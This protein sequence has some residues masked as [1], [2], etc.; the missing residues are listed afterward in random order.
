VLTSNQ[1]S[2]LHGSFPLFDA[3]KYKLLDE[4]IFTKEELA[5]I[6]EHGMRNARLLTIAPTG[7]TSL[8]ADNVSSG[9]EPIFGFTVDRNIK[10]EDGS[11]TLHENIP[12]YF[13]KRITELG[14]KLESFPNAITS[15][16]VSPEAQIEMMA[17]F[18]R[19]I[20]GAISKTINLPAD[21]KFE[22]EKFQNI[23][24]DAWKKGLKGTTIYRPNENL[25]VVI[26]KAT[27]KKLPVKEIESKGQLEIFE[28]EPSERHIV[29]GD[30][31]E[32]I[33]LNF[34]Y[35]AKTKRLKEV[36]VSIPKNAGYVDGKFKNKVFMEKKSTWTTIC[37]LISLG[38]RQG[39][40]AEKIIHQLESSSY[41]TRDLSS[42]IK[43]A[44]ENFV[45][46]RKLNN[47]ENTKPTNV[48]GKEC[49]SCKKFTFV[50]ENGCMICKTCGYSP[51]DE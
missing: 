8:L 34:T 41:S 25:S 36:F 35:D 4:S 29:F 12:D 31:G 2:K 16:Q 18:Q 15:S 24:I 7:T 3:E 37:R 20:D 6:R 51:C 42:L 48:I 23:Y 27:D 19:L 49:P 46:R 14:Y 43:T 1:L 17:K 11:I 21:I 38:L 5:S 47:E 39:I 13:Y 26:Q 28:V 33:Y 40:T 45:E 44:M 9:I 30:N 10:N 32:K 50:K 22:D